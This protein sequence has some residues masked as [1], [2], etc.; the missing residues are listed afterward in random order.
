MDELDLVS[1]QGR[2][3]VVDLRGKTR[4]EEIGGDDFG[5][6]DDKINEQSIVLLASG[7]GAKRGFTEEYMCRPPWLNVDGAMQLQE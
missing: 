1:L 2:G 4:D 7:W 3:V 6:Y 5:P